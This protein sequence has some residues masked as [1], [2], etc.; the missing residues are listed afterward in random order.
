MV[1][2]ILGLCAREQGHALMYASLQQ[3]LGQHSQEQGSWP[4]LVMEAERQGVAPLLYKHLGALEYTLPEDARRMLQALYLRS[5]RSNSIRTSAIVQI[6]RDFLSENIDVLLIK[7]IALSHF[8]YGSPGYRPMR[9]IDLLVKKDDLQKAEK[10]LLDLGYRP[11][12]DHDIP[13][14]YYHLVPLTKTIE[15]LPVSIELHHNL[16]P[17][18]AHYPLWPYEKSSPSAITIPIG[19]TSARTLSL[20]ESLWYVY[21]HGFRAPLTYEAFRFIHVAD[22]VN[23]VERYGDRIDWERISRQHPSLYTLL[24]CIHQVTPWPADVADRLELNVLQRPTRPGIP[25]RGWPK[26]HLKTAKSSGSGYL[27]L[28]RDT[29]WPSQWWLQVY[30]G[31][32]GWHH[33][34]KARFV[35]HPRM[36]W[37]WIKAYW[38]KWYRHQVRN[39]RK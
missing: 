1:R 20:E 30:Y 5:T 32:H 21:L 29:L 15:G 9:D 10:T 23:L 37:R 39:E 14:D 11:D 16:L 36:L 34:L 7:G 25:Y 19:Q 4:A 2:K 18:H 38:Y 28:V 35:D 31:N 17:L 22:I 24:G 12:R 33:D 27:Q 3:A 13:D 8:V 26:C 6:L